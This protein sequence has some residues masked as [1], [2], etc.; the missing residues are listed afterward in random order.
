MGARWVA[1]T[2]ARVAVIT[3]PLERWQPTKYQGPRAHL[4]WVPSLGGGASLRVTPPGMGV[5]VL[6]VQHRSVVF[7]LC[8]G[9]LAGCSHV[10]TGPREPV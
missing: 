3:L 6:T 10:E 2:A 5:R 9:N 7:A 8:S 4:V 1:V